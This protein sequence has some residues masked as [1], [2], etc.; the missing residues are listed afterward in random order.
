VSGRLALRS[1]PCRVNGWTGLSTSCLAEH[2]VSIDR[3]CVVRC[4]AR[5]SIRQPAIRAWALLSWDAGLPSASGPRPYQVRGIS[6]LR[7]AAQGRRLRLLAD[8]VVRTTPGAALA[9]V[10]RRPRRPVLSHPN[11]KVGACWFGG[12][13]R[14]RPPFSYN[15]PKNRGLTQEEPCVVV[16]RVQDGYEEA[17]PYFLRSSPTS[18][19]HTFVRACPE[20]K[21]A[22]CQTPRLRTTRTESNGITSSPG[23]NCFE[24]GWLRRCCCRSSGLPVVGA[25]RVRYTPIA[26]T[27]TIRTAAP[28]PITS[29]RPIPTLPTVTATR[30][31]V[32]ATQMAVTRTPH[33]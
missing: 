3:R 17:V 21:V 28:T 11:Q 1:S 8:L 19:R 15:S 4:S 23:G 18:N 24:L 29:I 7:T 26:P 20:R 10:T 25:L 14:L 16:L 31:T 22:R 9:V 5:R 13:S 27:A 6:G 12:G 30:A 32:T 33:T 2:Y